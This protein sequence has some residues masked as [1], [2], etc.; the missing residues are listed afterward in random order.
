MKK[1]RTNIVIFFLTALALFSSVSFTVEKHLCD[2]HVFSKSIFG[3][4][5]NCGM[6]DGYCKV[7]KNNHYFSKKSCCK[8]EIQLI[9]GFTFKKEATILLDK[10]QGVNLAFV[11]FNNSNL[12]FQNKERITKFKNYFP[13][14]II[15]KFTILYQV[16]RI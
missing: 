13:P 3:S 2:G 10:K 14:P 11:V 12:F 5:Q 7:E 15:K 16:F 6:E 4:A 8:D 9:N 1:I